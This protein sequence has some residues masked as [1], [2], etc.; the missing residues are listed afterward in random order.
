MAH[1]ISLEKSDLKKIEEESTVLSITPEEAREWLDLELPESLIDA[2]DEEQAPVFAGER[3]AAF[4][5]IKIT[6]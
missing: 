6:R 5:V 4:I 3:P 1:H 2:I